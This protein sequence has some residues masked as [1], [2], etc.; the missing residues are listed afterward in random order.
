MMTFSS[1]KF[2]VSWTV[3]SI[4]KV[5]VYLISSGEGPLF[6]AELS[7]LPV[8]ERKHKVMADRTS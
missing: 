4:E 7:G 8:T 3:C 2:Y 5:L 1:P 6:L